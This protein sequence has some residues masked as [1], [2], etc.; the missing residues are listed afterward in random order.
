MVVPVLDFVSWNDIKKYF[1]R[2]QFGL[3]ERLACY[4]KIAAYVAD[5]IPIART[6]GVME[7]RER[8]R[9]GSKAE[10]YREWLTYM[11]KGKIFSQAIEEWVPREELILIS[12]GDRMGDLSGGL[13]Q[14]IVVGESQSVMRKA[15]FSNLAY[16]L[17]LLLMLTG[18][19][20]MYSMYFIPE[21]AKVLPPEQWGGLA[22]KMYYLSMFV[23]QYWLVIFLA[24]MGGATGIMVSMPRWK[25]DLRCRFDAFPPWSL[26]QIYVSSIF[27]VALSAMMRAGIPF[28]ES[29]KYIK[30]TSSEWASAHITR[31]LSRLRGGLRP[32]ES[33]QT[34]FLPK[35]TMND[36]VDYGGA[37]NFEHVIGLIGERSIERGTKS[38]EL[39]AAILRTILMFI[40]AGVLFAVVMSTFELNNQIT[41][42]AKKSSS[43]IR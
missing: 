18:L 43:V 4:N 22:G 5:G 31:M 17:G 27:L 28:Q 6:V 14:A 20:F 11:Q 33:M 30:S 9:N 26:Y 23:T 37:S 10:M 39:G 41:V 34:G 42:M 8:E 29:L 32:S 25:G 21:M 15:I 38:I 3:S 35:E 12:S 2:L 13:K 1:R 19:I 36:V 40:V 7:A 24:I 16:P